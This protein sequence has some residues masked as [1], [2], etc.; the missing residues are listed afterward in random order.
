MSDERGRQQRAFVGS[1]GVTGGVTGLVTGG[2]TG[3]VAHGLTL[4]QGFR[5]GEWG[6]II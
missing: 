3:L 2:V 1:G 6:T 5:I 4:R